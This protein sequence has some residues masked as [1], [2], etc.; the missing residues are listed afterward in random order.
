[1]VY[2]RNTE[3]SEAPFEHLFAVARNTWV[4]DSWATS[5]EQM[6]KA[7]AGRLAPI[8]KLLGKARI[9]NSGCAAIAPFADLVIFDLK[10]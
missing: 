9:N 4:F 2:L 7:R 8:T 3:V 1:M 5:D 6:V 10:W